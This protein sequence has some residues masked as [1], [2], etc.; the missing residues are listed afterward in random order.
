VRLCGLFVLERIE[1]TNAVTAQATVKTLV[2]DLRANELTRNSQ[3]IN[4]GQQQHLSKVD[5]DV[6]LR[7]CECGLKSV[8]GVRCVMKADSALP[9]VNG[10]LTH[11]ITQLQSSSGLGAS[12]HLR[13]YGRRRAA[14]LCKAI[15]MK[16][17]PGGL[18][19]CRKDYLSTGA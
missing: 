14:F 5:H 10:P 19:R 11:A 2:R 6:F 17:H 8:R 16:R 3:Q 13:T 4:Q 7:C 18:L 15:I 12:R 1:V 9:L